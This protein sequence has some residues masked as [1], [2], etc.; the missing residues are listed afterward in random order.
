MR[1]HLAAVLA[2]TSLASGCA[3][4]PAAGP[5]PAST[6]A[7][8]WV[9]R[10]ALYEVFVRDFSPEGNLQGLIRGLDRIQAVGAE[11]V[12]LMPIHPIGQANRKGTLGSPYSVRD[13]RAV[14]PDYGTH[15]DFRELVRA[16]HARNM[17]LIIDWVPNHTAWDHPWVREHP[18]FYT[19]NERGE[20]THPRDNEG[21]LTDWTD[22]AELEYGNPGLR[23]AMI[24][25]MRFW[26]Q[27]MGVDGF[28]VDM[29]GM[30]PD[31]FW[32]EAVP[33]L[34]AVKPAL[35]LAEWEDP[36]M[37]ELGFDV[38]YAWRSYHRLKDVWRGEPASAFL[39]TVREELRVTPPGG[40][41]LRFTTNH[42]ETAWD[43]PPV[44]LFGGPAGAR[45]AFTAMALL[46]G[47]PLL[48]NG[49]EVE[50]PQKLP[51][52]EKEPVDWGRPG[53]EESR[54]FY[55]RVVELSRRHPAFTGGELQA[56]QTDA[57]ADVIAYRR[58]GALVLVNVRARPVR[59]AVSGVALGGARD[60]LN[61][62]TQHGEA[63]D[64]PAHG[65]VVLEV[66][67]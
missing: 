49:Q 26:L 37:F 64:L 21:K 8:D 4:S 12:W 43:Q 41:R 17:K 29:A 62:G 27:E 65:A 42:D 34:R 63:V 7:S 25:E 1:R 32:R 2:C 60:L 36:K 23:R 13:Y 16:V 11:V 47:P 39:K 22:V 19:R 9:P 6:P 33:Q 66:E 3:V 67:R 52:F 45:A 50:S 5:R 55:R 31:E 20:M 54:A 35:L 59:V 58:G 28:R 51:I 40:A 48:Y 46:P 56:V 14:H 10:T 57:P 61:G 15:E 38:T 24:A 18:E 30:L 44:A 53:A